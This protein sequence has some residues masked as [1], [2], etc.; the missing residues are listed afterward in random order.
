M[1][2]SIFLTFCGAMADSFHE[3]FNSFQFHFLAQ[4]RLL[5]LFYNLFM[6]FLMRFI[7]L[8]AIRCTILNITH[9]DILITY[10]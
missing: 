7:F 1:R 9:I 2:L 10:A 3:M 8:N 5:I 4:N 6:S